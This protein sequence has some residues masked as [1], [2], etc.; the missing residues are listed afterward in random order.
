MKPEQMETSGSIWPL[1]PR[2]DRHHS[3]STKPRHLKPGGVGTQKLGLCHPFAVGALVVVL[4][5]ALIMA[6]GAA[7]PQER[8]VGTVT[9]SSV[10]PSSGSAGT[11]ITC[12]VTG[13]GFAPGAQ[14]RFTKSV[15]GKTTTIEATGETNSGRTKITCR[16]PIPASAAPGRWDVRVR[17]GGRDVVKTGAFTVNAPGIT[18]ISPSTG[19]QGTTVTAVVSGSGFVSGSQVRLTKTVNG[20]TVTIEATGE[21]VA[22]GTKVS[23]RIPIP[24][25]AATGGWDVRVRTGGKELVKQ[26]AFSVTATSSSPRIWF[27]SVPPRSSSSTYVTGKVSGVPYSQYRVTVYVKVRGNWWGPKPYWSLPH[28]PIAS[29]GTFRT[30]FVTGGVD[31][32][33]SEFAAFLIPAS[34]DPPDISW[35]SSLPSALYQYPNVRATRS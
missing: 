1:G 30:C 31:E 19:K 17:T 4:T 11:T 5:L 8:T 34:Y 6:A 10:S 7:V 9:I 25:S 22:G 20:K 12:A 27:T 21:Q 35:G 33:T 28:T 23:C 15:N 3:G 2:A 14:V 26:G 29:D 13:A 24:A 32:E 16:V 18:A